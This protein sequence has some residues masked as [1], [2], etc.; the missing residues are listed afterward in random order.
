[1]LIQFNSKYIAKNKF[2]SRRLHKH[3]QKY[4]RCRISFA[5]LKKISHDHL[6]GIGII[7]SSRDIIRSQIQKTGQWQST[8]FL[9]MI[10]FTGLR[11]SV[12]QGKYL[13]VF[14][15]LFIYC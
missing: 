5:H 1:M 15:S 9:P 11:Y 7:Q 14:L 10:H 2:W 6:V 12:S 4:G 13:K 8:T 3:L